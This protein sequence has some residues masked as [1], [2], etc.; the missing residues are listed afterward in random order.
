[1]KDK[2]EKINITALMRFMPLRSCGY[3]MDQEQYIKSFPISKF[4]IGK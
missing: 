3:K 2:S 4:D 1:M